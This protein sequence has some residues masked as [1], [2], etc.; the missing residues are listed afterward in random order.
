MVGLTEE[1]I[2]RTTERP[3]A[4]GWDPFEAML[5]RAADELHEERQ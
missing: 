1:E 2:R 4:A 3:D 5:L